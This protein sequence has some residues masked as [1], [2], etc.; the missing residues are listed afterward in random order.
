MALR[1]MDESATSRPVAILNP[2]SLDP[3]ALEDM[4]SSPEAIH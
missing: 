2:Y 4:R 1:V 3:F